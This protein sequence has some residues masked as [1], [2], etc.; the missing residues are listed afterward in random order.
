M[1][2]SGTVNITARDWHDIVRQSAGDFYSL[3]RQVTRLAALYGVLIMTVTAQEPPLKAD[4]SPATAP[5][6]ED[7]SLAPAKVAGTPDAQAEAQ[8]PA[9]GPSEEL[10]VVSTKAEGGL[11]SEAGV[12]DE[13]AR[14]VQPL[15]EGENLLPNA[16]DSSSSEEPVRKSSAKSDP[17]RSAT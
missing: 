7:L 2:N 15:R 4:A 6:K 9:D 10:D 17:P 13:Q 12:L 11:Q 8:L 5:A 3:L 16:P 1:M 14:Q